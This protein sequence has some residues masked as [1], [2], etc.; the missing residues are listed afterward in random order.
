M[1]G[2]DG[3]PLK[4][5]TFTALRGLVTI[6]QPAISPDG[7]QVAYVRHVGD[8]KAD[9]VSSEIELVGVA[10]GTVRALTH[11][12]K[13]I[14]PIHWSP[15]GDRLGFIAQTGPDKLPQLFSLPMDGG[16]ALQVT[17]AKAG[18][19]DFAWKPDGSG[20]VYAAADAPPPVKPAGFVPAF[21]V[22]DEHFLTRAPSR[23]V[24]LWTIG[25][26]GTH[27][28]R[29]TSGT[30]SANFFSQLSYTPDGRSIV[31]TLQPDA[32]FAHFTESK[33]MRVDATTGA[34]S[35]ILASGV[36]GGGSLSP[37]GRQVALAIPRHASLYLQ[38]DI[39]V[40]ALG[41]GAEIFNGKSIDRN[42]HWAGWMPDGTG[43]YV[44]TADGVRDVLWRLA[45][46]GSS[47]KVELGDVDFGGTGSI[48]KNGTLAFVGMTRTNPGDIYVLP[49]DATQPKKLTDENSWLAQYALAKRERVDWTSDGMVCSG[50]L[51]YPIGYDPS[52]KYPLVLTVHG[53]PVA[54]STW[55]FNRYDTGLTEMLATH[56]YLVFEPNYRGSDNAGDAFLQA[57]VG[58]VTSG[59]GRDNL[60]AVAALEQRGIVDASRIGVGGWSGGGLQTSWLVGHATFWRAAVTGA[61][62]DDWFEQSV[63]ADINEEFGR[64]F[65]AGATPW[66]ATGRQRYVDES[67]IT[68]ADRIVT[69][70]LILSDV[71]D[72]RVPITQSF[73]L[74]RAL[75]D[76]GKTV[77]FKAWP[78]SG[79]F[80]TDPVAFESVMKAWDGW[81]VRWLK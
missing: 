74:Y 24:A 40:R 67:P 41:D 78:R 66:T 77:E 12:R 61:G 15:S 38:T 80:P 11:D 7:S 50:V 79:H 42:V 60:A 13:G 64:V 23:A 35:P 56:G 72:Q 49:A 22:T 71:G 4:P 47:T 70:L 25:S 14:G 62:V 19:A 75:R 52:K 9:E 48:A 44:A 2:A 45:S 28:K 63:L 36:D 55:D 8:Y 51:T 5:L 69:P 27:A 21:K 33:T 46:N 81:F 54:T 16:D 1:S 39:S 30:L 68:Y 57:I 65:F 31:A 17:T 29:L 58:D 53:G 34:V 3:A 73:Q 32:V 37:D 76:T 59:P 6:E 18:V 20:L 43:L 10:S 26:D